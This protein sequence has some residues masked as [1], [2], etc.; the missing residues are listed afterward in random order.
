MVE[1][2]VNSNSINAKKTEDI[3]RTMGGWLEKGF[4]REG[5]SASREGRS[6]SS[7]TKGGWVNFF[8]IFILCRV[9]QQ[10]AVNSWFCQVRL[11]SMGYGIESAVDDPF[12]C[13]KSSSAA[14]RFCFPMRQQQGPR[15]HRHEETMGGQWKGFSC[16]GR[17]Q[18]V[19][20]T[21]P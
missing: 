1:T 10:R 4:L 12:H 6:A 20:W 5:T 2:F 9:I 3:A 7:Q 18:S 15:V 11:S 13:I 21:Y 17:C 19:K 8:L 14:C 16:L